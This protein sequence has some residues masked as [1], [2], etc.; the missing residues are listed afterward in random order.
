MP[1]ILISPFEKRAAPLSLFLLSVSLS[2]LTD[3][4][5]ALHLLAAAAC[6]PFEFAKQQIWCPKLTAAA[7]KMV[8]LCGDNEL[9][10]ALE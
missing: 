5:L 9:S 3:M 7:A 6:S 10:A 8:N 4:V 2:F 1:I